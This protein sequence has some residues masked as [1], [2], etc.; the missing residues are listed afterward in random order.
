M[1]PI[2]K[3]E[4]YFIIFDLSER[5]F[6][7]YNILSSLLRSQAMTNVKKTVIPAEVTTFARLSYAC[8][9]RAMI[10]YKRIVKLR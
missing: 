8:G 2:V 10:T 6:S 7:S 5:R 3:T 4:Y 1:N 9:T